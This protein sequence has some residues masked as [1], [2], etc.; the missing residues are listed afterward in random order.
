MVAGFALGFYGAGIF[1]R[2][3][4]TGNRQNRIAAGTIMSRRMAAIDAALKTGKTEYEFNFVSPAPVL[5]KQ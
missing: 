3:G 1:V 5:G 4:K 2:A